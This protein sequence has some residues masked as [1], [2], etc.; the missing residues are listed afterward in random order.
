MVR[1]DLKNLQL[2]MKT[3]WLVNHIR[4]YNGDSFIPFLSRLK[5]VEKVG[6]RN[7]ERHMYI[8]ALQIF[9]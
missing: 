5:D 8:L 7:N 2:E 4:S 9:T 3:Q 1:I 6:L